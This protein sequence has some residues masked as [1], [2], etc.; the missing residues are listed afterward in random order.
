[1]MRVFSVVRLLSHIADHTS[2]IGQECK[3]GDFIPATATIRKDDHETWNFIRS[4]C[5]TW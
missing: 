4:R 3:G 2:H 5:W 1:M